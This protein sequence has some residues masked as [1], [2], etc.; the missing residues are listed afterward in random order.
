MSQQV[1]LNGRMSSIA[2]DE[3]VI[4]NKVAR[5]QPPVINGLMPIDVAI[6]GLAYPPVLNGCVLNLP[7]YHSALSPASFRSLDTTKALCTA[8]GALW[9]P[10]GRDCDGFD[11]YLSIPSASCGPLRTAVISIEYWFRPDV[12]NEATRPMSFSGVDNKRGWMVRQVNNTLAANVHNGTTWVGVTSSASLVAGRWHHAV[13]TYNKIDERIYLNGA[14]ACTPVAET[15][16]IAYLA[17]AD[18]MLGGREGL[19]PLEFWNGTM[20]EVR[21]YNRA[22]T[23]WEIWQIYLATRWRYQ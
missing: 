23:Y 6:N 3:A 7:L 16:D 12:V 10:D 4:I 1:I 8:I 18:F 21:I 19:D 17:P 2:P 22:L 14:L 13:F 9:R 20:G 5:F 11:D 15:A